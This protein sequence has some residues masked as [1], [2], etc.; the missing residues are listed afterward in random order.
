MLPAVHAESRSKFVEVCVNRSYLYPQLKDLHFRE[1]MRLSALLGD[2]NVDQA[3]LKFASVLLDVGE[4]KLQDF[5][6]LLILLPS[7]LSI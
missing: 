6:T 2:I 5:C 7:F 1:N 4:E 3:S